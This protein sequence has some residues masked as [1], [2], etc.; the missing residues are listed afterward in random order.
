MVRFGCLLAI[1]A[2]LPLSAAADIP[3]PPPEKG[4]KRVPYENVLKLETEFRTLMTFR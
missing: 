4:F 2:G 1:V 3:P